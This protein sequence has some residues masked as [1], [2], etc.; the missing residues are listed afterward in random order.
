M[1]GKRAEEYLKRFKDVYEANEFL[2]KFN[3]H[4]DE[5]DEFLKKF[6]DVN[7]ANEYL[8]RFENI[9]EANEFLKSFKDLKGNG[10]ISLFS[11]IISLGDHKNDEY[12]AHI[13]FVSA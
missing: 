9:N 5:A 3:G 2:D 7:E 10:C 1:I 6:T 12:D 11:Y 13:F 4:G 8:K